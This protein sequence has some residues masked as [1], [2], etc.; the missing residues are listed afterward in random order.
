MGLKTVRQHLSTL[1]PSL[2]KGTTE[3]YRT[4]A[5]VNPP[6]DTKE[7]AAHHAACRAALT[8]LDQLVKLARWVIDDDKK[9]DESDGEERLLDKTRLEMKNAE[10]IDEEYDD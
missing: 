6:Y 3:S 10:E 8:H 9:S 7:F 1:L 2:M 5:G 4:F